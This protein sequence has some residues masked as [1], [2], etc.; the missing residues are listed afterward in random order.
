MIETVGLLGGAFFAYAAV[1]S[2]VRTV[3]AGRSLGTPLDLCLSILIGLGLLYAY[4]TVVRG[5]DWVLTL[6][7][8]VE[9]TAWLVLLFYRLFRRSTP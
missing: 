9:A 3:R 2:A 6:T 1:P 7:Y 5:F 4:L 8:S